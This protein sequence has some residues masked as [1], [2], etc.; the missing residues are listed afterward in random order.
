MMTRIPG[1]TPVVRIAA[2]EPPGDSAAQERDGDRAIVEVGSTGVPALEPLVLVTEGGETAYYTACSADRIDAIIDGTAGDPDAVVEHDPETASL[3]AAPL[4]GLEAGRRRVLAGCGWRRPTSPAD[5]EAAGGFEPIDPEAVLDVGTTLRGRGWG[6]L[7]Q[8]EFVADTWETVRAADGDPAV[9]VNAHGTAADTLLLSSVPFEVLEGAVAAGQAVGATRILVYASAAD[10]RVVETARQA[11]EAYP[12]CPIPFDVVTGPDRYRAAEPTM[13]LEALEG[14]HRL[15][16]RLRPPGPETVG[17]HGQPTL[18]HTPR[19]LAQLSVARRA[20]AAQRTRLTTVDGDVETPA[21]V[22]TTEREPLSTALEAV[23]VEGTFKAARV[24]GRFGGLTDDL[25]VAADPTELAAADLGT[26][27]ALYVLNEGRC[28]VEFVG[29]TAQFAA[30]ENCG[31]CVPC[32]EGTSQLAGL[33]RELYDGSYP[34][35]DIEELLRVMSTSSICAFGVEAARPIRTAMATFESTFEAHADGR[36]P[37]GQC[38]DSL[39]VA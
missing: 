19:T 20:G 16:A 15:E 34:A 28:L 1:E 29:Q 10:G 36:C 18:L 21:T 24:G 5:H 9:V 7:C 4:S 33:L 11:A 3:P 37:A 17:L 14:N 25:G 31:R 27:G 30:E 35:D 22:E 12:E 32:R 8:D 38:L 13:A 2:A 23:T 39:E 26:E 6:D